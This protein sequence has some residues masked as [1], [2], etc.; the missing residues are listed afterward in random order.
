M[1][2]EG[3]N[4]GARADRRV[5]RV[6]VGGL[7]LMRELEDVAGAIVKVAA[8]AGFLLLVCPCRGPGPQG[9]GTPGVIS[10]DED[11]GRVP[12]AA[13]FELG[14]KVG[15]VGVGEGKVVDVGG[16]AGGELMSA[17]VVDAV[18][19]GDWHVQEEKID[20]AVVEHGV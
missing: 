4:E 16:W 7:L 5:G 2:H 3:V 18:W 17:A 8:V 13:L 12:L 1:V 20:R 6:D 19:M 15:E 10:H 14:A 9:R 11:G